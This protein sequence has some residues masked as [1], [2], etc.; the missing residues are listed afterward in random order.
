MDELR[1]SCVGLGENRE[2]NKE[3]GESDLEAQV[4]VTQKLIDDALNALQHIRETTCVLCECEKLPDELAFIPEVPPFIC[5]EDIRWK[6]L[7]IDKTGDKMCCTCMK[8]LEV[9]ATCVIPKERGGKYAD[10]P[11][12]PIALQSIVSMRYDEQEMYIQENAD[13][14]FNMT[15]H[16]ADDVAE[17]VAQ[18]DAST[19]SDEHSSVLPAHSPMPPT[20]QTPL[21]RPPKV[22]RLNISTHGA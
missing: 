7:N 21:D 10:A 2:E 14:Y 13:E 17:T 5:V 12:L 9:Y 22:R 18:V 11:T 4:R 1:N 8:W 16:N 15:E 20:P 3:G 19:V 6:I